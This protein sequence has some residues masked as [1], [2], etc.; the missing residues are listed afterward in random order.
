[1]K[2]YIYISI[3]FIVIIAGLHFFYYTPDKT[4]AVKEAKEQCAKDTD[5]VL[6]K[7]DTV[8]QYRDNFITVTKRE[9]IKI[10]DTLNTS[11]DSTFVSGRDSISLTANVKIIDGFAD[12]LVNLKHKDAELFRTDTITVYTPKYIET[13]IKEK[14]WKIITYSY[15]AGIVT[16]ITLLF[17][18]N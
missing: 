5:T 3:V 7:G 14:D 11:F 2:P 15:I 16:T 4:N 12:W 10:G 9:V 17:L 13:V 1:M 6:V 18:F 8:I